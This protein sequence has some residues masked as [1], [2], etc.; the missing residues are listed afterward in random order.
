MPASDKWLADRLSR[1]GGE[2]RE[3]R[4]DLLR[5]DPEGGRQR[6]FQG[7]HGCDLFL[8]YREPLGLSQIQLTFDRRAVEWTVEEGV[9]TGRLL[10]FNPMQ[11]SRDQARLVLDRSLDQETLALARTLLERASVDEVTLALVRQHLGLK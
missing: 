1:A 7:P 11:P 4:G 2:L 6:W 10:S 5:K 3:V 9:R 8:W